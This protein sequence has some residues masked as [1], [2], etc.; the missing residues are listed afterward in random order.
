MYVK[1]QSGPMAPGVTSNTGSCSALVT[2]LQHEDA[3]RE[4]A[5]AGV[6]PFFNG[7]G[8]DVTPGEVIEKLDRNH[9]KLH[10]KDAKFF[11]LSVNPSP[12]ELLAMGD[13][14]EE[15]IAGCKRLAVE[16]TDLYA[17]N[18]HNGLSG[19][20]IMIFWKIHTTRDESNELQIHLHG[21]P[22]RK[23]I[24]N[25]KQISPMSNHR[26]TAAGAVTGG[27]DRKDFEHQVEAKFDEIFS[28]KRRVDE[29]FSY[30]LTMKKGTPEEKVAAVAMLPGIGDKDEI[31]HNLQRV[32][33]FRCDYGG[34]KRLSKSGRDAIYLV[35]ER[36][37]RPRFDIVDGDG[38]PMSTAQVARYIAHNHDDGELY[39][40]LQ[41]I[42]RP[43]I[44]AGTNRWNHSDTLQTVVAATNA[45]YMK[46]RRR[47]MEQKRHEINKM[48]ALAKNYVRQ[49]AT[50][51]MN[52]ICPPGGGGMGISKGGGNDSKFKLHLKALEMGITDEELEW[53]MENS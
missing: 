8:V 34:Y 47:E 48:V 51:A 46:S 31:S 53:I 41:K 10:S 19:D 5:G 33:T 29:T 35:K 40:N 37:E 15:R 36:G 18:F 27:F 32:R 9:S 13:T 44:E 50:I 16:I 23:D 14:E 43:F 12:E 7:R 28:Y 25:R 30:K 1:I 26:K 22:S 11:H 39:A 2:Y 45:A 3:D 6:L 24:H 52:L 38:R 49:L 17:E 42:S 21:V 4:K 20:D